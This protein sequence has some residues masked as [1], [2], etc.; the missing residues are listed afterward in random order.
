MRITAVVLPLVA[1]SCVD[2]EPA[3]QL[4][5][6][7]AYT[8]VCKEL[9]CGN[10]PQ[11]AR[12]GMHEANLNG[13]WGR[14]DLHLETRN[15]RA[16][17]FAPSGRTYDLNVVKGRLFGTTAAGGYLAH[18][19]LA[20]SELHVWRGY[21]PLYNITIG[22]A[23]EIPFAVGDPTDRVEVYQMTW[24][25]VG[26]P[27]SDEELCNPS[28][29]PIGRLERYGMGD[30]DVLVYEG[31]RF[32]VDKLTVSQDNDPA[33][34]NFGCSGRTLAKMRL[35]RQS[36]AVQSNSGGWERRQATFKML[37]AD[38]CGTGQ[39]YT[40]TGAP[41]MFADG[42]EMKYPVQ[43][44]EIEALWTERGATCVNQLRLEATHF[45]GFYPWDE[46]IADSCLPLNCH[47]IAFGNPQPFD[48]GYQ[49]TQVISAFWQ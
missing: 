12:Y 9:K 47:D 40:V 13:V 19:D 23:H 11:V 45:P 3:V 44:T 17:L 46:M 1:L 29:Y 49:D 2:P 41:I 38:Y 34:F 6:V 7:T 21:S 10:S 42:E 27:P 43:P 33:W 39:A 22:A 4:D 8:I 18:G 14:N 37:C 28:D 35:L 16:Q 20:G 31:D 25:P 36:K 32:N 30:K 15:G 48:F 24:H 5:E 26:K